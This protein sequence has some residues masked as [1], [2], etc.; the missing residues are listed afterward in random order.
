MTLPDGNPKGMRMI[1]E[2]RGVDTSGWIADKIRHAHVTSAFY[3]LFY[4]SSIFEARVGAQ[5]LFI[6]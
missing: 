3:L 5:L 2:E 6:P 4:Y 1:L